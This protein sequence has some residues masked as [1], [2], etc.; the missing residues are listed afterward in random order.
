MHGIP[1]GFPL[2]LNHVRTPGG[3]A[4]VRIILKNGIGGTVIH[5]IWHKAVKEREQVGSR[6][7]IRVPHRYRQE[8]HTG[9]LDCNSR[10]GQ[11][12]FAGDLDLGGGLPRIQPAEFFIPED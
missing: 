3:R 2:G 5:A 11:V 6:H 4:L 9:A 10:D 1:T 7:H 8:P 12:G